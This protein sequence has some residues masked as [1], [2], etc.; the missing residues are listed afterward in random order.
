VVRRF[1]IVVVVC[2]IAAITVRVFAVGPAAGDIGPPF[3]MSAWLPS[4]QANIFSQ[5]GLENTDLHPL[6]T[7]LCEGTLGIPFGTDPGWV[8]VNGSPNPNTP[9]VKGTGQVLPDL[10]H[11]LH[12]AGLID[13][14]GHDYKTNPFVHESDNTYNHYMHDLNIMVTLDHD[15]TFPL[16]AEGNWDFHQYD[17]NEIGM[18]EVEWERGAVPRWAWPAMNDRMTFWGAHIFDCGHGDDPDF[19]DVVHYRTEVHPPVGWVIYRNLASTF[20]MEQDPGDAKRNQSP[21][22]WYDTGSPPDHQG[23][24]ATVGGGLLNTPVQATVAD[25]FFSDFGGNT[26]EALN[27]CDD[28]GAASDTTDAVCNEPF[29]NSWRWMQKILNQDY[30]FFVPAPPKP[31][32]DAQILWNSE[33]RCVETPIN[34]GNPGGDVEGA[35]EALP[36]DNAFNIGS[37]TCVTDEVH[38]ATGPLGEPGIQVTVQAH[39]GP[40]GVAGTPDDPTYPANRYVAF[41]K[42]Y[43]VAWDYVAPPAQ[44]VHTYNVSFDTLQVYNDAEDCGEDGEWVMGIRVDE[45][46]RYPIDGSGDG[47]DPF[48]ENGAIDDDRCIIGHTPTFK[49]YSIG[50]SYAV[51]VVPGEAINITERSFDLDDNTNDTAPIVHAYRTAPGTYTDG[52]ANPDVEGGHTITYTITDVTQ[53][54]PAPGF[55]F[56]G[57]PQYGPTLET[58]GLLRVSGNTPLIL[59]G[60]NASELEYKIWTVGDAEPTTW[61]FDSSSPMEV[62]TS[63]L[64][65]GKYQIKFAAVSNAGIVSIRQGLEIQLDVTPPTLTVPSSFSTPATSVNGANVSFSTSATDTLPGPV[66]IICTP[67]SGSFFPVKQTT[68][69]HCFATDAVGNQ[70]NVGSFTIKVFSPFGYVNDFVA[71]GLQATQVGSGTTVISGNVGAFDKTLTPGG[72]QVTEVRIGAGSMLIGGP[73]VAGDTVRLDPGVLAGEV[74]AVDPISAGPGAIFGAR[75]GY[76]PLFLCLPAFPGFMA[77]G[78]DLTVK[79]NMLLPPGNYGALRVFPGVKLTLLGGT[80]VFKSIALDSQSALLAVRPTTVEVSLRVATRD[81]VTIGPAP[82][83]SNSAHDMVFYVAAPDVLRLLAWQAGDQLFIT[84][85]VYAKNGTFSVGRNSVAIGAFIGNAVTIGNATT[86]RID[87]AFDCDYPPPPPRDR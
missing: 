31:S 76:V 35:I 85:N 38:E 45:E 29:A 81:N 12:K 86:M 61:K 71:L 43:K 33:D 26:V 69:V 55:M 4:V 59:D 83:S 73:Q 62:D 15:D 70:S 30:T 57:T 1:A 74:Y 53:D 37:A 5:D 2:A 44:R 18:L 19:I 72:N 7:N 11:A 34:P 80:Y 8:R 14:V 75:N 39:S 28:N 58:D 22:H 23:M 79:N 54:A 40:D 56:I 36:G 6:K 51:D 60:T 21:W 42:R 50:E 82:G 65:D 32:P 68:L 20:D 25:A 41:G 67:A 17:S 52:V 48:W 9:F 27:G 49:T 13:E 64:G 84:A 78:A 3:H 10:Y 87:S 77:F 46:S 16:L 47:G 66:S 63:G 24:G